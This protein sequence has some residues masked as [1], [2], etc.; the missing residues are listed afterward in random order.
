VVAIDLPQVVDLV[1]NPQGFDLLHRDCVNVCDWFT[2]Q[3][4]ECDAEELFGE[5]VGEV[6]F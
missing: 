2:R 6:G 1:S 5:L 4:L 3:R